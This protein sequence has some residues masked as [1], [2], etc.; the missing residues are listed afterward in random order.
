MGEKLLSK[1]SQLKLYDL[2]PRRFLKR[3]TIPT[4]IPKPQRREVLHGAEVLEEEELPIVLV[5]QA[6][7]IVEFVVEKLVVEEVL[8]KP[9]KNQLLGHAVVAAM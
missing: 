1:Q 3:K 9:N 4:T 2:L 5:P 6:V 8:L 7:V